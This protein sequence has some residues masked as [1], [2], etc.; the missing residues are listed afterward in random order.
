[1][2]DKI[3]VLERKRANSK[4]LRSNPEYQQ[5]EKDYSRQYRQSVKVKKQRVKNQTRYDLKRKFGITPEQKQEMLENQNYACAICKTTEPR[6][7]GD[8]HVDHN[9]TTGK[10]R[11]LLCALCNVGLGSFKDQPLFLQSAIDY[12]NRN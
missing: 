5:Y 8:W 6:G 9:H 7:R 10:V 1:V 2:V 3:E 11:G 4:R 12:L